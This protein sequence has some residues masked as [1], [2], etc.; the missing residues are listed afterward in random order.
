DRGELL[1]RI[2]TIEGELKKVGSAT[3]FY[4]AVSAAEQGR[5]WK[6]RKASLGLSM[7]V[8]GDDKAIAFVEDTAVAPDRLKDYIQ[9]FQEILDRHHTPAGFYAHAS[10]GLLHIRPVIDLKTNTGVQRFSAIA[11]D[12]ANLVL[13]FGGALSGEHGDGLVRAPFQERMFG[14]TLYQAFRE[15]KRTFD[16]DGLLNPGKIVDA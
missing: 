3:S 13:E 10:V 2:E 12:V 1:K 5:I 15:I 4:R 14:P 9:R 16:P 8:A 6:L 11:D 7:A